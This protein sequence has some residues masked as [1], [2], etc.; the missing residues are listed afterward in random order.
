MCAQVSVNGFRFVSLICDLHIA[1]LKK[2]K[3]DTGKFKK[4][5][6]TAFF[7]NT[8]LIKSPI[9][10][11]EMIYVNQN[12]LLTGVSIPISLAQLII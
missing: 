4:K 3:D 6:F 8:F 10:E 5:T 11:R 1:P 7:A 12:F 9:R 2:D